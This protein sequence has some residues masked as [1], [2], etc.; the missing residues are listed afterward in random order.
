[1][2]NYDVIIAGGAITGSSIAWF[3]SQRSG[4]NGRVLVVEKDLSYQTCSSTLSVSS[5]RQQFSSVVNIRISRFGFEFLQSIDKQGVRDDGIDLVEQGYLLLAGEDGA[6]LLRRNVQLQRSEGADIG[7]YKPSELARRYPWLNVEGVTIASLG[8]SGEGWFDAYSLL[9]YFKRGAQKRG[10]TY[11]RG[12]V[13]GLD[14]KAERVAKVLLADGSHYGC[15]HFV[16]AGGT[17]A[18]KI[19]K[20]AGVEVCIEPRKRCVFVINCRDSGSVSDCPHLIDYT[21]VWVKPKGQYFLT[22]TTPPEDRDSPCSDFDVDHYLF[23]EYVWPALAHRIPVFEATKVVAA[24]AGHYAY[25]VLDQNAIIGPHP[26]IRNFL[27]ANGFSG[28]G[29]QQ[30]PAVGRAISEYIVHGKYVSLDLSDLSFDRILE[31]RP[32]LESNVF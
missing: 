31:G 32:F 27:F 19:A 23:D 8:L 17:G 9:Q 3:L 26:L 24:W 14:V 6:E 30:A 18:T 7:L 11:I 12:E 5:I 1:M 29:L 16:N 2:R 10:V 21:G 25:N 28:H 4:F 22:G 15:G 13:A 20:M